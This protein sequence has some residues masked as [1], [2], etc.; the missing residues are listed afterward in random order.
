MST[1]VYNASRT[2]ITIFSIPTL[3]NVVLTQIADDDDAIVLSNEDY[4]GEDKATI[5]GGRIISINTK[6]FSTL[7]IRFQY[8]ADFLEIVRKWGELMQITSPVVPNLLKA[9]I[10][11]KTTQPGY[12][13]I[14]MI[15]VNPVKFPDLSMGMN[16]P[17]M[18]VSFK[19][20]LTIPLA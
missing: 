3:G 17:S 12:R 10:N 19:S 18:D 7:K 1:Q 20:T 8:G 2:T 15:D 16:A 6:Q 11:I 9:Y 13:N 5:N 14:Q 4:V